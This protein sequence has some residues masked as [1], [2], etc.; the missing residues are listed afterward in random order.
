MKS[1]VQ[2][3]RQKTPDRLEKLNFQSHAE[4]YR[5][6][7]FLS[8]STPERRTEKGTREIAVSLQ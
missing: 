5:L 8:G 4:K 6:L 7:C 3:G 2:V 1:V